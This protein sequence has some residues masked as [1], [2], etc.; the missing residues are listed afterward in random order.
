[1]SYKTKS[2]TYKSDDVYVTYWTGRDVVTVYYKGKDLTLPAEMAYDLGK[3]LMHI[4]EQ[5]HDV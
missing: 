3:D 5:H 2:T 1:M 4:V